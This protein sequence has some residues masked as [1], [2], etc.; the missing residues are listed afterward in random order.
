MTQRRWSFRLLASLFALSLVAAACGDDDDGDVGG[1]T[2]TT[3]ESGAPREGREG[4]TLIWAHEQEPPDLHLDDPNNNLSITSWII[5]SMWEGLFG[6][7]SDIGFFP[8]LLAGEPEEVQNPDGSFTANFTLRDGLQWSDGTPLT[9]NDVK[10]TYDVIM[11]T[12]ESGE[13]VYLIGS[14]QGYDTITDFTVTSD[15]EFSITWSKF[16]AGYPSLFARVFPAHAFGDGGAAAVNEALLDWT[17]PD[18][19]PLPS[20]GP[21][22]FEEWNRGVSMTLARNE[23]YHGSVSPDVENDGIA[24]VERVQIN[25]VEDTDAQ[26]NALVSGEAHFIFTQPQV[27]FGDNI[28]NNPD[29]EVASIPGPSWEHIGFNLLNPHLRKPEVREAIA[30]AIDKEQIMSTLYTPLYGD[31]LPAEGL[32]N[33]YWMANQEHYVDNQGEA[34]YGHGDVEAARA[35]LEEA[36]YTEG[37]DG[38]YTHPEDGRLSLR[39][40]TTGGN[41]LRELQEQII[42]QMLADAGIEIVIDNVPGADYFSERIFSDE[43]IAAATTQGAEG[44]PTIWDITMFAWVGGPWPGSQSVA[45][46]TGDGN[47]GYGYANPEFDEVIARCDAT[48]DEDERAACYNEADRYVTTLELDPETGLVVVPL[49]QKPNFYAYDANR[50]ASAAVAVDAND[51]GPLAN[52]V[53]FQLAG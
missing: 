46:R 15:T 4:G 12:D 50:L 27:E 29:F 48:V 49:T 3:E 23:N 44:D 26:I 35:K 53:D 25:F 41:R 16:F 14:R 18:G 51:A 43:A 11:E 9:A 1:G 20:S 33:S 24:H 17:G 37:S 28:A 6:V 38:V 13:F 8:E 31:L 32:G 21:L 7:S 30:L 36:G 39:I 40:G 19:Q 10:F 2:G 47:N 34:G 45:F 5:Q 42:Q 22:V 52:V